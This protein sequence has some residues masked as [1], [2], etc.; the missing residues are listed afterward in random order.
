M[1]RRNIMEGFDFK[2]IQETALQD[3]VAGTVTANKAV[4]V[5]ANKNVDVLAVADLKLGAGAGTSVARTAAE[6]NLLVKGAEA[7][8]KIKHGVTA[9]GA[10]SEDVATGLTTVTNVIVS[11]VGDPS[12]THMFSTGTIGN[13]TG[14]PAAGSI[15]IKSFKPTAVGDCTPIAASDVFANVAWIAIGT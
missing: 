5:G 12:M 3:L 15:R 2:T 14:Q 8:Y 4:V 6:I 1:K 11:M 9:I 7:G 13:Q 10:A